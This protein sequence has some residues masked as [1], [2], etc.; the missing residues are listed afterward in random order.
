MLS[1][2]FDKITGE[3][4]FKQEKISQLSPLVLAYI[5]DAVYEV[6]IRTMLVSE[7]DMPVHILHKKSIGF[8][9]AK[10]Q[11]DIIHRIMPSL[12]PEEHD[13]VRRGRNTKSGTIPKNADVTEYKYATGFESLVGFLYL[14]KDYERLMTILKM[15]VCEDI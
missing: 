5:G 10:A 2:L 15:A 8:V 12:T 14:K 3:F 9:K 4:N 11:S 7:G 13:V 1:E 6:F